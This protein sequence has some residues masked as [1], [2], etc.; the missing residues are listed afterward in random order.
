LSIVKIPSNF[1]KQFEGC[2]I[3]GAIGDAWGSAYE[4]VTPVANDSATFYWGERKEPLYKWAIT[5]DT[6]LTLATCEA[7]IENDVLTPEL[8]ANKFIHYY[9]QKKITGIGS[10]TLKS[11]QEMNAGI[12]WS[13]AGR[14]GEY[15]AGNG[16]AMRI[17]PLA[18]HPSISRDIIRDICRISHRNDE[19]YAAALAIVVAIRAIINN[20]WRENSLLQIVIDQVPDSNTRDKLLQIEALSTS[21]IAEVAK[22]GTS[23]Y[24]ADSIPFALFAASQVKTM[25]LETILQYVIDAGGDTDTNASLTGQVAGAF[26]TIEG[27]PFSLVEKLKKLNEYDWIRSVVD[28]SC[29]R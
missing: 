20:E 12:H 5:D 16:A 4:N 17:A 7:I 25:G 27:I 13:Q 14:A 26:L 24:A 8:L 28:E 2:I 18:F 21:S 1:I 6:Q 29:K 11:L 9:K 15:A 10:S 19:A 23:G 3:G 22:M